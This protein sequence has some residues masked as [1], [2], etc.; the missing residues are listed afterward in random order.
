MA[1]Y[2]YCCWEAA[3]PPVLAWMPNISCLF[4]EVTMLNDDE[5]EVLQGDP[6]SA[7]R[8]RQIEQDVRMRGW[9]M[10]GPAILIPLN[11][12]PEFQAQNLVWKVIG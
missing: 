2:L 1:V 12:V 4:C 8:L 6:N 9:E 7:G 11:H 5:S 10:I 3:V